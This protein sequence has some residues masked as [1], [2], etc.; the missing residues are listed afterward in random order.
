MPKMIRIAIRDYLDSV[1]T[2]AFIIS[3]VLA[4]VFMCGGLVAIILLENQVDTTDETIAVIDH[5]GVILPAIEEAAQQHNDAVV[6]DPETGK[7]VRPAYVIEAITPGEDLDALRVELSERVEDKDLVAFIEIAENVLDPPPDAPDGRIRYHSMDTV[8]DETRRWIGN[9]INERIRSIRLNEAGFDDE[10]VKSYFKWVSI[11]NTGLVT[12]DEETGEVHQDEAISEGMAFGVPFALIIMMFMMIM[13]GA[14]PLIHSAME[15]KTQRISEVLLGSVRPF[16]LMMGK[17][18]GNYCV[19]LTV[20]LVYVIGAV[21]VSWRMEILDDLPLDLLPWFFV[22]TAAAIFM[23]GALCVAVGAA[24]NDAKEAQSLT[25]PIMLPAIIPMMVWIPV[26]KEPLSNFS[27]WMSFIP[28]FT[29]A[30]MLVRQATPGGIPAWQP[31]VGLVGVILITLL[32]VWAGGRI[33]RVGLLMQ[34]KPP[35]I[36]DLIRWAIR[37]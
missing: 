5:S 22:N 4:P 6:H 24:C 16:E 7:K 28:P 9:P 19:S 25:M 31:W 27:T 12:M 11:E 32:C 13:T 1:R 15:E 30:L 3:V 17:L 18:V 10:E 8:F 23:F 14:V 36:R 37:G 34:G 29:P 33:F 2:K 26:L 21:V 35:K 20:A